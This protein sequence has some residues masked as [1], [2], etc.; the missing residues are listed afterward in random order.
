MNKLKDLLKES[1]DLFIKMRWL[2][3]IDKEVNK[4]HKIKRKRTKVYN[5]LQKQEYI[6]D[7]M[8]KRY[9]EIY[10]EDLRQIKKGDKQE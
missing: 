8:M 1:F 2:K 10:G 3:V 9:N 5:K 6:L 7:A 4:Y